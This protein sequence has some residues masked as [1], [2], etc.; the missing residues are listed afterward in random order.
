MQATPETIA[1]FFNAYIKLFKFFMY[2]C[3]VLSS[4][5]ETL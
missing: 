2:F 4:I 5:N 1:V 3:N